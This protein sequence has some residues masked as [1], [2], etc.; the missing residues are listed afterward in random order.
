M[1]SVSGAR[2]AIASSLSALYSAG[3]ALA[4]ASTGA[5][6]ALGQDV[7]IVSIT[8]AA[9]MDGRPEIFAVGAN[10]NLYHRWRLS[11][12]ALAW[13][14][15]TLFATGQFTKAI[16]QPG[17]DKG[18]Y[19][20][21]L[22]AGQLVVR[23]QASPGGGWLTE[24]LQTGTQLR[25]IAVAKNQDDRFQVLAVGGNGALW[26]ISGP[27]DKSL[28]ASSWSEWSQLGGDNLVAVVAERDG[29]GR[30][31]AVALG[32]D[33][34]ARTTRQ[35]SPN[36]LAV[37]TEWLSLGQQEVGEL[38]LGRGSDR[39]LWLVEAGLHN[40]LVARALAA[41]TPAPPPEEVRVTG[42][43]SETQRVTVRPP[44][45]P[46]TVVVHPPSHTD[47]RLKGPVVLATPDAWSGPQVF[48]DR[49]LLAFSH[50]SIGPDSGGALNCRRF[51]CSRFSS[52]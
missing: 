16:A 9:N 2:R 31:T 17:H 41:T 46:A 32:A 36:E 43:P 1:Q 21:G 33:H 13:S 22:N 5:V 48:S 15:W 26:T 51:Y 29:D 12:V 40:G 8:A 47:V 28:A 49:P 52:A 34:R 50:L 3:L 39:K 4:L 25:D 19:L 6:A 45:P 20:F 35:F 18:L 24:S 44:R 38:A 23:K 42:V 10:G 14:D 30:V 27:K 11:P 37:W 7:D